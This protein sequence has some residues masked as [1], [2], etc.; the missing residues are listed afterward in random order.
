[1]VKLIIDN[2]EQLLI[3]KLGDK[4]EYSV[5]AL[6][7]GDIVF[8]DDVSMDPLFIIE[9]KTISDLK[10]SI[11]DGRLREQRT[12][13]LGTINKDRVM[14][15]IEGNMNK[16]LNYKVTGVPMSTL[17]G[18]LINLSL[19]DGIHVYKTYSVEETVEY[20][21]KMKDK[22]EKDYSEYFKSNDK[23]GVSAIEYAS[24]LKTKKKS[25][26]T[27]EVFFISQLSL[28]TGITEVIGGEI[29]KVYPRVK[30]LIHAYDSIDEKD[31][32]DMLAELTY[33]IKN[34][35]TRRVGNKISERI[36][37]YIYL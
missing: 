35:K 4:V 25:N 3:S 14:Y 26:M 5:E 34:G 29:V 22:L 9:R 13:L 16:S 8:R 24:T 19:R 31:R 15:L 11:I 32:A 1:M 21:L 23:S 37:S 27:K 28:I 30:D 2:R 12:R 17:V 36:Y 10:A 6:D 7:L 20:I 33:S 18:S